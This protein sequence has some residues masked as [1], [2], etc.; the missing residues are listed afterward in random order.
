MG[1]NSRQINFFH[2]LGGFLFKVG[3]NLRLGAKSNKYANL[4]N[5]QTCTDSVDIKNGFHA[6]ANFLIYCKK[7]YNFHIY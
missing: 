5:L 1:A 7:S 2:F 3:A 4:N 6:E